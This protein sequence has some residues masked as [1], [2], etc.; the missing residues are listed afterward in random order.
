LDGCGRGD[1]V[2]GKICYIE[3]P[4]NDV[5]KSAAFYTEAFGWQ[6][7]T[8]GDGERAFDDA[9]GAVSGTWVKNRPIMRDPGMVTYVMVDSISETSRKIAER[10]GE[11]VTGETPIGG[12][13]SFALFRDPAGNVLGLYQEPPR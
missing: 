5:D 2:N 9:T 4:T 1:G 13:A 6:V 3:I 8:R 10:G 12:G 11:I 7:R